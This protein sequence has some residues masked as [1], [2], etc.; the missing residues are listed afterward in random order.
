VADIKTPVG[1][2]PLIPVILLIT[3][4]YLA[5]FGIHYWKDTATKW[6]STPVKDVLTGKGIPAP[7]PDQTTAQL[8]AAVKQANVTGLTAGPG[9]SATGSA[10]A[11]DALKYQGASYVWG[12]NASAVGDWDCSSFVSYVLGHDLGMNLPG[13]KWGDPGFP[14]GSHGPTTLDYL[15]FGSPLNQDQVQAGDLIVSSVHMGIA[16]STTQ[17]I[18]AQDPALGTGIS[19]FPAGFPGGPPHYRRVS[20]TGGTG[21]ILPT[22]TGSQKQPIGVG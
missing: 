10:I 18:S 6:P 12:G 4:G 3:G 5:W 15:L 7:V 8:D 1:D 14:P 19:D 2:A 13:G 17:M 16:I 11:D 9:A 22:P 21:G 20:G